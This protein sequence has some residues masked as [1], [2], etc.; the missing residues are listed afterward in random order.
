M[1]KTKMSAKDNSASFDFIGTY[2]MIEEYRN[3]EYKMD[4]GRQVNIHFEENPEGV[5]ITETFDAETENTE[6]MQRAGWQSFLDNFKKYTE[7]LK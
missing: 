4:D 7:T 6:E 2:T 3:I 5:L 1:F